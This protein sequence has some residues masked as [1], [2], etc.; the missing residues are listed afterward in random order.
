MRY[1]NNISIKNKF[2]F[3]FSMI[4]ILFLVLS[5]YFV[6][7]LHVVHSE[8]QQ[9]SLT[10]Q[11]AINK[12]RDL[13]DDMQKSTSNLG[14]M[15][16]GKTEFHQKNYQDSLKRIH[17]TLAGLKKL[18]AIKSNKKLQQEVL[19]LQKELQDYVAYEAEM[20]DLTTNHYKNIPAL[21]LMRDKVSPYD[22]GIKR[23]INGILSIEGQK[24]LSVDNA[25]TYNRKELIDKLDQLKFSWGT[26]FGELK[27]YLVLHTDKTKL[28][29]LASLDDFKNQLK[30]IEPYQK[31][32]N[33]S[34]LRSYKRL[35]KT[36]LT[37]EKNIN[38][39]ITIHSGKKWRMDAY[40][41]EYKLMPLLNSI[42]K[43]LDTIISSQATQISD[44]NQ[45]VTSIYHISLYVAGII[46]V[47]MLLAIIA[48]LTSINQTIVNPI[49]KIAQIF[50]NIGNGNLDDTLPTDREDEIG[51]VFLSL[52]QMQEKLKA[53][54]NTEQAQAD[55]ANIIES[56]SQGDLTR[57]IPLSDKEGI[58]LIMGKGVNQIIDITGEFLYKM[59]IVL[60]A[61]ADGDLNENMNGNFTGVYANLQQDM[62]VTIANLTRIVKEINEIT[63]HVTRESKEVTKENHQLAKRA[64]D[65]AKSIS[66]MTQ[67][68]KEI[69]SSTE[70]NAQQAVQA[71]ELSILSTN[72]AQ[73]GNVL[74]GDAITAIEMVANQNK[75]IVSIITMIDEIAF[76]TNLLALNA[77]VEAA[78]AGEHGSGFQVVA[79]EVR[80]LALRSGEAANQIKQL[81]QNIT[82]HIDDGTNL[83]KKSGK[84][85]HEILEHVDNLRGVIQHIADVS[86]DQSGTIKNI[87]NEMIRLDSVTQESFSLSEKI[88]ESSRSMSTRA[89]HLTQL[90]QKFKMGDDN[91]H[92][93]S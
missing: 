17:Q 30:H 44:A 13:V 88:M 50:R 90:M 59:E 93:R 72:K 61:L 19:T 37:V 2:F 23:F 25:A 74:A 70:K 77:A 39:I 73:E 35:Q 5:C 20:I 14:F 86:Q 89:E 57:R 41:M 79:S 87:N 8:M 66:Q 56:A 55:I 51:D 60:K 62:N 92:A 69:A 81:I 53:H 12:S 4:I 7:R 10:L 46:M 6:F 36:A 64:Q 27:N 31:Y 85:L 22:K 67:N 1:I 11:P 28:N 18:P 76:Q 40:I 48:V 80:Q 33:K 78:R 45:I 38:E 15:L 42:N 21:A 9:V 34:Q 75:E 82:L 71:A 52:N 65:Q 83:V 24:G 16:L 58:F 84:A 54:L 63:H 43:R 29:T 49:Q 32:F 26:T 47:F 3:A 91:P 68:M